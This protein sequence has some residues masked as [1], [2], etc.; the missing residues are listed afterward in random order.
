MSKNVHSPVQNLGSSLK[1]PQWSMPSQYLSNGR[2]MPLPLHANS[3]T[4]HDHAKTMR[5]NRTRPRAAAASVSHRMM[6]WKIAQ[7]FYRTSRE[8]NSCKIKPIIN[9]YEHSINFTRD[10]VNILMT[11]FLRRRQRRK[12]E[13]I[14]R[15]TTNFH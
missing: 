15:T 8:S 13:K 12:R 3:D 9:Y 10:R 7:L 1:S 2:Q 5:F 6:I 4:R 14:F 11:L